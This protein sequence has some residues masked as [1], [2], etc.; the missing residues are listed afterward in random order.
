MYELI[1]GLAPYHDVSHDESL[2]IKICLGLRPR[3]NIE[4]PQLI[5][6][7]IKRCLDENPLKRPTA[8]EIANILCSW[9]VEFNS[10]MELK[11]KIKESKEINN[12]ILGDSSISST[13]SP[14]SYKTHS[15][16]IYTSRLINF[17]NLPESKNSDDYYNLYDDIISK[18]YSSN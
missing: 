4:V 9:Y 13:S 1:S 2:A 18:E 6:H 7:L 12:K 3:F 8:D 16:A 11:Q 15:R 14:L 5:V 10:Q 17:N